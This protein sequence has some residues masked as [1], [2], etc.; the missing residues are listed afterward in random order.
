VII[1]FTVGD[2]RRDGT[3]GI[4]TTGPVY[5]PFSVSNTMGLEIRWTDNVDR[6]GEVQ[7]PWLSR[8]C[9][10]AERM[11]RGRQSRLWKE[12][13]KKAMALNCLIREHKGTAH[14]RPT[15]SLILFKVYS[16]SYLLLHV[17]ASSMPSPG[18]LHVP[19]ELLVPSESLLIKLCT[20][21]GG[22]F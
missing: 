13:S 18:S 17:S 9:I 16:L 8:S 10:H 20:M 5:L 3:I 22:G 21:D 15:N 6:V 12:H 2:S 11:I 4:G 19:T 1:I 14:E 7:W